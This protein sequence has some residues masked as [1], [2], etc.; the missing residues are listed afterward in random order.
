M[1]TDDPS[2][3]TAAPTVQQDLGN[4]DTHDAS[5]PGVPLRGSAPANLSEKYELGQVLGRGGMGEVVLAEDKSIG[6]RVA[7]KRMRSASPSPDTVARFLREAHIQARLDHPAIVPVHELGRDKDGRPYFTMKR[8]AGVTLHEVLKEGKATPQK[9][10]RAFVDVCLAVEF[11]HQ[12]GVI[13]RDLKP[14]NIMLGHYGEVYVL[15]WGVARVIGD[16]DLAGVAIES[17]EGE[18]QQGAVLGTPGYMSPEQLHGEEITAATDVYALGAILFEILVGEPLHP[19]GATMAST[20]SDA[21]HSPS[22]RRPDRA[23]A[24]ELDAACAAALVFDPAERSSA[25][26][27]ADAVQRYLD[28]DRDV[29]RRRALAADHLAEAHDA[30]AAGDRVDAMRFAGRALA[31]HPES[32]DAAALVTQLMLRPPEPPPP[33]LA[34]RF[35]EADVEDIVRQG[36]YAGTALVGYLAFIPALAWIGIND[37]RIV[38]GAAAIVL[39]M[40]AGALLLMRR[41]IPGITFAVVGNAVL[42]L[43]LSRMFSP[44]I[45]GPALAVATVAA[46]AS[47]PRLRA[48]VVFA[49]MGASIVVPLLLE[50][51]GL[52][53]P[54]VTF[55][56]GSITIVS[57]ALD[58]GPTSTPL[59]LCAAHVATLTVVGLVVRSLADARREAQRT[60]AGQSWMLE[61]LLPVDRR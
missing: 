24:P 45:L 1:T 58:L 21:I 52:L 2:T 28:G 50:M 56:D 33:A 15:D 5:H 30:F 48:T 42:M 36:L 59:L 41:G 49:V 8:L 22:R 60:L 31:L 37:W 38:G 57:G 11:A 23:F 26:D 47:F 25:R 32:R 27:L 14:S 40:I 6:R 4:E 10:L 29:E 43:F 13:H 7:I 20:L 53:P 54:T 19:R 17:L 35:D 34:K 61:Q 39:L 46:F 3:P 51:V 9:L 44:L 12:R 18:T 16:A 55:H